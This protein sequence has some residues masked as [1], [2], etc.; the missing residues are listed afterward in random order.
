M[1]IRPEVLVQCFRSYLHAMAMCQ[2]QRRLASGAVVES[3][4]L[5]QGE[6]Q[7]AKR[8][9]IDGDSG[10]GDDVL[11]TKVVDGNDSSCRLANNVFQ[12]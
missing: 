12:C 2:I 9:G 6:G 10:P 7:L 3:W 4:I 1:Y 5:P 8:D 11:S